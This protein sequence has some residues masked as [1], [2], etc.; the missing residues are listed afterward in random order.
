ME[1]LAEEADIFERFKHLD[2][3][4]QAEKVQKVVHQEPAEGSFSDVD[5]HHRTRVLARR[6][7]LV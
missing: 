1:Y 4:F 7:R 2:L 3:T 5:R 6:N